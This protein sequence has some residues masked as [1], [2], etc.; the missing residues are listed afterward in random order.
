MQPPEKSCPLFFSNPTLKAEVLSSPLFLE[1]GS[2]PPP[3]AESG[4]ACYVVRLFFKKRVLEF[5]VKILDK[6]TSKEFLKFTF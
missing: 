1:G 4:G 5:V 6:Y 3:P 2:T